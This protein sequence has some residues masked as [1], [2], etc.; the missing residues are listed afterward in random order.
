[1]PVKFRPFERILLVDDDH[2]TNHVN[3]RLIRASALARHIDVCTQGLEALNYLTRPLDDGRYPAP[4][5]IFLDLRMPVMDGFLFLDRYQALPPD[6]KA[7][8]VFVL[9]S[10]AGFYDREKIST[11]PEV[12]EMLDKP[13]ERSYA[14]ELMQRHF[15]ERFTE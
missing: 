3:Q 10:A 7:H 14:L 2:T 4:E 11:Y 12:L 5:I 15:P 6:Q 13:L 8:G 1:M 9:S